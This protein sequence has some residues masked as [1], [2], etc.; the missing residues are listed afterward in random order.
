MRL[1]IA[2]LLILFCSGCGGL[3]YR[4]HEGV[5]YVLEAKYDHTS[6]VFSFVDS[7]GKPLDIYKIIE[8]RTVVWD[9]NE[10]VE[11]E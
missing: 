10:E 9:P 4:D 3:Y 5:W 8:N 7:K 11:N 6:E 1:F 2:I